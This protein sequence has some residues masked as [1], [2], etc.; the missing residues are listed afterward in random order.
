M[1]FKLILFSIYQITAQYVFTVVCHWRFLFKSTN[2]LINDIC[3]VY[4]I[5]GPDD[6]SFGKKPADIVHCRS[7]RICRGFQQSVLFGRLWPIRRGFQLSLIRS[8]A[9]PIESAINSRTV[10]HNFVHQPVLKLSSASWPN[11]SVL[12]LFRRKNVGGT[13][14]PQNMSEQ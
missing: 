3:R 2:M 14:P 10:R 13:I 11:S 4:G 7:A 6:L 1:T 12:N 8:T 9:D 5:N